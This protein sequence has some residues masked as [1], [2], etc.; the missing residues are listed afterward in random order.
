MA[1]KTILTHR[2]LKQL[3]VMQERALLDEN[4]VQYYAYDVAIY[5]GLD[6]K[7]LLEKA[8]ARLNH[9]MQDEQD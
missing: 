5:A 4:M 3:H 7:P 6:S 9:A 2:Q 8:L 1:T